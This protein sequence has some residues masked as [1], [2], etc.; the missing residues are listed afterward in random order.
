MGGINIK[1]LGNPE[2]FGN[3]VS[4]GQLNLE[5]VQIKELNSLVR[6]D[7]KLFLGSTLLESLPNLEYVGDELDL[8]R[9]PIVS[10]PKLKY[11]GGV[12]DLTYAKI[13]NLDSLVSVNSIF[14]N[15]R[16]IF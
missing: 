13:K 11:V 5:D 4:I 15:G 3:L 8:N 14:L 10:L 2:S 1:L 6:V 12:L 16:S 7:E 9:S